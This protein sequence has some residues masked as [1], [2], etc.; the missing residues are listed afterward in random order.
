[1]TA[2]ATGPGRLTR[3]RPVRWAYPVVV[4]CPLIVLN[5]GWIANSE[6]RNNLTEGTVSTL[7]LGVLF[8]LFLVTLLNL[9]LRRIA[10]ERAAMNQPELL[11]LYVML[12]MSSAIAGVSHLGFLPL[13]LPGPYWYARTEAGSA[14]V[15]AL[16]PSHV[17]PRDPAILKGFY[18]GNSTF[19][20]A[21]VLAAWAYPLLA[22]SLFL[23]VLLWTMLCLS[24]IVRRRWADEEHLTFPVLAVP[25]EITREGAPLYRSGLMWIGFAIPAV[26]HSLNTLNG[27]Y[28][29]I[30]SLK[31]NSA[32]DW[33][34]FLE[35]PW[36][37]VDA[38]LVLL[39]PVG[40]GFG[41]LVN[42]DVSF[43]MF[44]FYLV[45]KAE[46]VLGVAAG[47]RDPRPGDWAGD[48]APQFPYTTCQAWGA[49]SALVLT[50][51]WSGYGYFRRYLERAWR[52]DAEGIDLGEPL[53]ARVAVGGFLIGF[54]ALCAFVWVSG[55]A[56][57]VPFA[58]LGI[59]LLIMVALS[60]M[61]AETAVLST[62]LDGIGPQII[63]P[64]LIGTRN[65][66]PA[67]MAHMGMLSW[68]NQDYRSAAMP[69]EL[70]G[71]VGMRRAGGRMRPLVGVILLASIVAIV[72]ALL[73][74]LQMYYVN[75][76]ATAQVVDWRNEYALSPWRN[77]D[78]WLH[79]PKPPDGAGMAAATVGFGMTFLLSA[80]RNR[81]LGFP[82]HPAA[83][84]L[85]T[86]HANDYFWCDMGAAWLIKTFFLRYGGMGLYRKA[87]P[88]F[89]G[90]ILGD[91][92]TGGAWC[93]VGMALHTNLFRTFPV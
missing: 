55:G 17:G 32:Q 49:W 19:F 83:Y 21:A 72:S 28:P 85:N 78:K 82:L 77:M 66:A 30:P 71:L 25:L 39:H 84:V 43:S 18:Q 91:F 31:V 50:A 8:L 29:N 67:D 47:W 52:G 57:W 59:Y 42:T 68:F 65:I 26:L 9:A 40:I 54:L 48:G 45:K 4:A 86:S 11:T 12:S 87:M 63:L 13:S 20:Q 36:T 7:F 5:C 3:S 70:E 64:A 22:W 16:L 74:D 33:S 51:L 62:S 15:A 56:I 38:F 79:N 24:V 92:V 14:D 10:G 88:F 37:G 58:F 6:I 81:F 73:W 69:Q 76:A 34:Q 75:G 41:Y 44:F 53:S 1:M 80:L 27:L 61:R 23:L 35:R 93:F 60:R 89:L 46:G 90:L 2:I